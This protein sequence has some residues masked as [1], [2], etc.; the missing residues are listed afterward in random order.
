M[1]DVTADVKHKEQAWHDTQ[2]AEF[3]Q[4][5][6]PA[7]PV[8][9]QEHFRRLHLTSFCDGG[10]SWWGDA[11]IEIMQMAG[12]VRGR[13][14]LDYGCGTG[15][16]GVYLA[17]Q[18]ADVD[19]FDLS[20][21]GVEV[22][23]RTARQ[24][25]LECRFRAMDAEELDYPDKS[26]DLVIGFGVLHHV[27]KYPRSAEQLAHVLRPGARAFFHETLWDNPLINFA[28]RF[29][30]EDDDAG[31]ALL[32]ERAIL[33]W[34]RPFSQVTTYKR[35]LLYMLKRLRRLPARDLSKPLRPRPFWGGVRWLDRYLIPL[36]LSRYCGEAIVVLTR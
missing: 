29:T 12:N 7:T 15:H 10:W 25:N 22:A 33:E 17:M 8:A 2:Y 18:G 20:Q 4:L 31:D 14:V 24:Y 1:P 34:S 30:R 5:A 11:R 3:G 26:F 21:V 6:L 32:T 9:F 13:K 23:T 27:I 36:G 35:N 28:R 19:G 16:L